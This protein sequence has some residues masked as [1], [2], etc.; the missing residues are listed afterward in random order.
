MISHDNQNWM[1]RD[2][3]EQ[4]DE[5]SLWASTSS[6]GLRAIVRMSMM[7]GM[8]RRRRLRLRNRLGPVDFLCGP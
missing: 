2:P 4:D 5:R 3:Q 6:I 1:F 7:A 8:P